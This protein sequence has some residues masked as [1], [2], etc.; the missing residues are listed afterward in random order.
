MENTNFFLR[1]TRI[2]K[3]YS[4]TYSSIIWNITGL[5]LFIQSRLEQHTT[6]N[7]LLR[8]LLLLV[9]FDNF[10]I[11]SHPR[12]SLSRDAHLCSIL[13]YWRHDP[14]S[15]QKNQRKGSA[16]MAYSYYLFLSFVTAYFSQHR[17]LIILW[18]SW[19]K[20]KNSSYMYGNVCEVYYLV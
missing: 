11:Y 14:R 16:N 7:S 1:R 8:D 13:V 5:N 9:C 2:G 10:F 4:G 20:K 17:L 19:W 6:I 18:H 3:P 12:R 15:K